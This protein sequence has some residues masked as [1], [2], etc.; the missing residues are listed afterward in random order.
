MNTHTETFL[1]VLA[2]YLVLILYFVVTVWKRKERYFVY[3]VVGG[4]FFNITIG[5]WGF[6]TMYFLTRSEVWREDYGVVLGSFFQNGYFVLFHT[7]LFIGY[8]YL[9][10][11]LQVSQE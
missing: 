7:V 2:A 11:K 9:I 8:G 3:L 6:V 10:R 1:A 4:I 5:S